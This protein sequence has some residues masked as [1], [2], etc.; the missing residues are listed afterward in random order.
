MKISLNHLKNYVDINVPVEELCDRMV[1]AGFEVESIEAEGENIKNVVAA[2]IVKLEPHRDSDH[3][4]ICQ[5]DIGADEL[6]QIVTGAQNIKEGDLVPAAL[7]NSDLP[8]GMHIKAGKLRGVESN[9]MLCSGEELCL[10]EEDYEGASVHGILILKNEWATG[11]DMREVLGLD[12]YIIDFKIT[13]NR[14]DCNCFLGVAKEASV[15]LGSVYHPPVPTYKTVGEDIKDYI[16]VEVQ[17]YDLCPRYVGR[18]VKNLRIKPSPAWMQKAISASGMRPINNIV[19]ITNFVMLETGQP[20]HAFNYN[21][22]ADKKIIVRNAR[23]GEAITTLDGKDYNL[24]PDMLVIADGEKPSCLAGIMGGKESEI[25]DDTRDLFLES[26]KFRRDSVRK[27][28]R[29]LGIRTEASGR[30]EK[31]VDI[32]NVGFAMDRALQLID[33]LDAG[34]IIDGALD[35][36]QGLPEDKILNVTSK[37]IVDLLGVDIPEDRMVEILNQLGLETTVAGGMLTVRVPSIRDDIEGRADLAEEVMRIYGYDHIVGSAM[38]GNVVRGTKLPS[39]IKSDKLK[40]LLCGMGCYE[41]ATYSFIASGALDTLNLAADDA[42]RNAIKLINPLGDEY[43]TLR[44]QLVSSMLTVLATNINRKIDAGRFFEESKRFVA[45]SLPL[46]EQPDEL[47]T[48]CIGVYGEDEDFF[49]LKGIVEEVMTLCGAH[50]QYK[51]SS[52]PYLHP[53]RQAEVLANNIPAAVLGEVHPEVAASYG[54]DTRVYV[55]EIKLD[56]LYAINKRKTTYKPLPKFPA[57]ERDFAMLCDVD[58]PVGDLE[59]AI[60][61]G[62]GRVLEKVELFDVYQGSQ[63]PEGKKSVAYSVWLRSAEGTLTDAQIEE[64]SAKIIAKLEKL[65]AELRK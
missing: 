24:T 2:R 20:M 21:D 47:P 62:G 8:N 41:I 11:T 45:K 42:R 27:T 39:R 12:D 4:Q 56:V 6:V 49:T 13:A 51:R 9:G 54:I 36:N 7:D 38:R 14:P 61:S 25:E 55:A 63:I 64:I 31:G 37:S 40:S 46:N 28:G 48:L 17:N 65:G 5:M 1:M 32:V 15:V 19:D 58:I 43:S 52:E 53:G 50:T 16:D 33:E 30:F 3:L 29:A 26:A 59:K 60:I 18:V 23:E 34:D 57:V 35:R 10:T 44:T 22:L